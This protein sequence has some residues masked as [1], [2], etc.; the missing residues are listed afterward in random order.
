[1]D[2]SELLDIARGAVAIADDL[3]RNRAPSVVTA[4]GD[5][6]MASDL[7]FAIEQE[8]RGFLRECTPDISFLG[9]EEGRVS[10]GTGELTWVLD[11]I[12]GTAN[13][14][15]GLPLHAVSL[16][17]IQHL[18]PIIGVISTSMQANAYW[19]VENGG[20]Y[21][22]DEQIH[23][24]Q[25]TDLPD[26]IIALGDYAVGEG[27]EETNAVRFA[28]TQQ[29]ARHVQ[30]VRM[31]GSAAIDLAWVA[32]GC[33]AGAVMLSNKPWD[34]AAGVLLAREAGAV[35]VDVQGRPHTTESHSTVAVAPALAD[36]L[37]ALLR[38]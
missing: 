10:H 3:L 32:Q 5:R 30:R 8:V 37:L 29:L 9:E 2:N 33:L 4:K 28:I 13:F 17:L 11:P 12:D 38:P 15:R 21:L 31:L 35:V 20:A 16:G 34:T 18:R 6:D 1:M 26:A 22:G 25:V 36:G 19:A 14:V 23:A 7:D 27:A 24:S